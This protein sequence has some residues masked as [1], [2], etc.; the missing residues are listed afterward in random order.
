MPPP[1]FSG[2]Q[3][4]RSAPTH[5]RANTAPTMS[6][7]ESSAPT[8]CRW[9]FSTGIW[10][11]AASASASRWN[12]AFARSRPPSESADRSISAKISGRLRWL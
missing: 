6:M 12:S 10:W 4:I 3:T 1:T 11:I 5:S 9:T 8:S 2:E 7:I